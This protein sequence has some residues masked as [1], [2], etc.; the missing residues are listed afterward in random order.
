M[1]LCMSPRCCGHKKS[2]N[3]TEKLLTKYLYLNM[4]YSS[5]LSS[6]YV[7]WEWVLV[8]AWE[9]KLSGRYPRSSCFVQKILESALSIPHLYP[10]IFKHIF[11]CLLTRKFDDYL[12]FQFFSYCAVRI[13][14][15][16]VCVCVWVQE[17]IYC[18]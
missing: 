9:H 17:Y 3:W 1:I 10:Y 15:I 16:F 6:I 14:I 12:D 13:F 11:V 8:G 18:S 7:A 4:I 2:I 5:H